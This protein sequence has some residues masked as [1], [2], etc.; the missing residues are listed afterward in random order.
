MDQNIPNWYG[1]NV[2]FNKKITKAD[3]KMKNNTVAPA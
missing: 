3:S 2:N 1:F